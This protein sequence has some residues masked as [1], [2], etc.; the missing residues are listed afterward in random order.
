MEFENVF[1]DFLDLLQNS[2]ADY[3]SYI[4][5]IKYTEEPHYLPQ[6][7]NVE[8]SFGAVATGVVCIKVSRPGRAAGQ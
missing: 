8:V 4:H 1:S 7:W 2:R 3:N 5:K 6:L